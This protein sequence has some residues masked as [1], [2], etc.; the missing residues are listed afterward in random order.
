MTV[1]DIPAGEPEEQHS[2]GDRLRQLREDQGL[3]LEVVSQATKVSLANLRAIEAQ[4]YERL[5]ADPFARGMVVLYATHLGLDGPQAAA[6]FLLERYQG[7]SAQSSAHQNLAGFS[8]LPKKLSEP[9]HVSSAAVAL[10]MLLVIV[11][12]FTLF[13]LSTSWNPFAFFTERLWNSTP[14]TNQ[15]FHPADPATSN[16][17][18]HQALNLSVH[19]L[20]DVQ[21]V[22]TMD[23]NK[24]LQQTYSRNTNANWSAERQ[25]RVEFFQPDSAELRLNGASLPFPIALDGRHI[26][27]LP[28]DS[29]A[30]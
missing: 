3:N 22:V 14:A 9:S 29:I 26:L 12:S 5:P 13:C 21:V 6:Q 10:A 1:H 17:G 24:S 15:A 23:D 2:L 30:P 11:L 8:L 19:F 25:L 28:A 4:A 18:P 7:R 20:K 27:Q 16:G